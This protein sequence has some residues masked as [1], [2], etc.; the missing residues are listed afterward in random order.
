MCCCA[1]V[2]LPVTWS[3]CISTIFVL[4]LQIDESTVNAR[5]EAPSPGN[6]CR[7]WLHYDSQMIAGFFSTVTFWHLPHL[8]TALVG[9]DWIDALGAT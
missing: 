7:G 2:S 1:H 5:T 4:L 3:V 8:I 9:A 6:L